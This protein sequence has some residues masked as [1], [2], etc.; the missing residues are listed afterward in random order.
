MQWDLSQAQHSSGYTNCRMKVNVSQETSL[1]HQFTATYHATAWNEWYLVY[2][3]GRHSW[4][5]WQHCRYLWPVIIWWLVFWV[6]ASEAIGVH[7]SLRSFVTKRS[8]L[9]VY[10]EARKARKCDQIAKHPENQQKLVCVHLAHN[11][12]Q[13][14]ASE[15]CWALCWI[16][17]THRRGMA[18]NLRSR[19]SPTNKAPLVPANPL[20][21]LLT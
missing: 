4:L 10:M 9:A 1:P 12:L 15:C 6:A 21:T 18:S 3:Q 14:A 8:F 13:L 5:K 17:D 7:E 11:W 20:L 19:N 16:G 2:D